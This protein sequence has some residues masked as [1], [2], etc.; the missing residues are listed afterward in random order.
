MHQLRHQIHVHVSYTH[1]L[2]VVWL[3]AQR[4]TVPG[5]AEQ[6]VHIVLRDSCFAFPMLSQQLPQLDP[7]SLD[8]TEWTFRQAVEW[9]V[10]H[11]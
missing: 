5:H 3:N 10:F 9:Q 6:A 2:G 11:D 7:R 8:M 1:P 4:L